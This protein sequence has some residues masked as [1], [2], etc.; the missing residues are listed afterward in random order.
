MLP[1]VGCLATPQM[2]FS[3]KYRQSLWST[4]FAVRSSS[5]KNAKIMLHKNLPP[6]GRWPI[7]RNDVIVNGI[8]LISGVQ[9]SRKIVIYRLHCADL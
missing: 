3:C 8:S 7:V 9:R 2:M 5:A 6:Y 4:I 1:A